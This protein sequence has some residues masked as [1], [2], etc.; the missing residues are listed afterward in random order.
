MENCRLLLKPLRIGSPA[1]CKLEVLVFTNYTSHGSEIRRARAPVRFAGLK[2]SLN[3]ASALIIN[4]GAADALSRFSSEEPGQ[5]GRSSK[6]RILQ[7]FVGLRQHFGYLFFN[8]S[9]PSFYLRNARPPSATLVLEI[10]SGRRR[11]SPG[12]GRRCLMAGRMSRELC[13]TK[14]C[15]TFLKS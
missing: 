9:A 8:P 5:G 14:A 3:T 2:S 1:N 7:S 12:S 13:I 10:R 15:P 6:S 4:N 11:P